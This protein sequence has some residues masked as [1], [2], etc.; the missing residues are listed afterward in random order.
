MAGGNSSRDA[1]APPVIDWIDTEEPLLHGAIVELQR[2][3]RRAR[4]RWPL[5]VLIAA[6]I[7]GAFAWKAS[8]KRAT[9]EASIT[10]A[11]TEGQLARRETF[12]PVLDLR[13][14]VYRGAVQLVSAR[15]YQGQTTNFRTPGGGF[16]A[17]FPVSCR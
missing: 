7:T 12:L 16:A 5:I 11:L 14:Y 8:K 10:L 15:L 17:V 1:K 6:A 3:A 9:Y 4:N 13:N 2:M